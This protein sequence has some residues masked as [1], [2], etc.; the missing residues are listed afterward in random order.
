MIEN[1]PNDRRE[2]CETGSLQNLMKYYGLELSEEM[3][4]GIGGALYLLYCPFIKI[5]KFP[6]PVL[7]SRPGSVFRNVSK[8]IGLSMHEMTFGDDKVRSIEVL[9]ELVDKDIPVAL[10]VNV[11]YL[12]YLNRILPDKMNFNGHNLI[13]I[14]R[15]GSTY[16][17]ADSDMKLPNDEIVTLEEADLN[18]TR[19]MPGANAPHGRLFYF[20][21]PDLSK[22]EDFDFRPACIAGLKDVCYNMEGMPFHYFGAKGI[23]HMANKI[24]KWDKKYSF[25]E[26]S[27]GLLF[28]Y[29][30]LEMAGTGGSGYRYIYSRFLKECAG[31]FQDDRMLT[32]S[33]NMVKAADAWRAFS[34][35]IL[36]Y[37]KQTGVTL[38]EMSEKLYTAADYEHQTF[39]KIQKEFLKSY[40]L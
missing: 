37:R 1:F 15:E 22:F 26:I 5:G 23:K 33:E 38:S 10:V 12:P 8:R 7:R 21:R 32:Y 39:T 16:H 34:V 11:Y 35:D 40:K 31:I 18:I 9:N 30:I 6:F 19:F 20:D 17:I 14:G 27:L 4:F 3:A 28:Y 25:N 2:H 13:V 24:K 29:R 36:H